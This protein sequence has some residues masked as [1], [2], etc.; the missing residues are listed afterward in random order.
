MQPRC[1]HP[2]AQV[3]HLQN[4]LNNLR[5]QLSYVPSGTP[6]TRHRS[7]TAV[8]TNNRYLRRVAYYKDGSYDTPLRPS[9]LFYN[10]RSS[11]STNRRLQEADSLTEEQVSEFKEA[12]SLFVSHPNLLVV[13]I[14]SFVIV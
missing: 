1:Y 14:L 2:L 9:S 10:S 12:F 3:S 6:Y 8:D 13:H 7:A 11:T 4:L 5:L